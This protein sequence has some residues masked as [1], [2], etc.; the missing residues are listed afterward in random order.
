[1]TT[2]PKGV[3][4]SGQ[5]PAIVFLHSSLSTAKQWIP[6]INRLKDKFTC[7][8]I[9]ILGYGNADKVIDEANYDF[10]VEL[11]RIRLI[12]AH[13]IAD[14]PYHLVGHSCGGA[15]ALKLAV[16]Q[17]N[18]LLSLSL[19]EPVAFHLLTKGSAEREE[20]DSFAF[21]VADLSNEQ[22]AQLFTDFWNSKGFFNKLPAKLQAM[23]AADMQK[24]N[25]D[26]KGLI[27]ESYQLTD[28]AT[29][30]CKA[31]LYSGLQSPHLSQ[32]LTEKI[33]NALPNGYLCQLEAGHMGPINQAELV[34]KE[35]AER[36][37]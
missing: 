18:Q 30:T 22:A 4:I 28:L 36:I 13:C 20:A 10:N 2:L 21:K 23:M 29:I 14:Q 6:L 35:M 1:M 11:T 17:P 37:G 19:Y 34:L 9:D 25:L 32:F 5:G 26:F 24:V 12:L 27:S 8:N 15:I 7:I 33:A 16:E 31:T 3:Y